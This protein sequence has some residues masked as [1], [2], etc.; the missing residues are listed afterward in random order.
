MLLRTMIAV[1]ILAG[2]PICLDAQEPKTSFKVGDQ[3]TIR[4]TGELAKE[5][6]KRNGFRTTN[7]QQQ[8]ILIETPATI[9]QKLG[10]RHFM[11]EH[12]SPIELDKKPQ[13]LLTLTVIVDATRFV[14]NVIPKN[15]PVYDSPADHQ[16]GVTPNLLQYEQRTNLLELSD[17][18]GIKLRTWELMDEIG[19]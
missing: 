15:T 16:K 13:R 11:I 9:S 6:A 8:N 2:A 1:A 3:L 7:D 10:D 12:S 4:M 5:Y 14:T 19:D 17:L 18:K